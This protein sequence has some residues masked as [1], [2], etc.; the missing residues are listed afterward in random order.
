MKK[1]FL[2]CMAALFCI[3]IQTNTATAQTKE[4]IKERIRQ[5]TDSLTPEQKASIRERRKHGKHEL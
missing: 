2:I 3:A 4:E 1:T 5:R